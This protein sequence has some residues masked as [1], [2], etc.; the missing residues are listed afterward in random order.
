MKP[1]RQRWVLRLAVVLLVALA[2]LA[3]AIQQ[4]PPKL[5][6]I[7][8]RSGRTIA[9][10]D[11]TIAG[12][13]SSFPEV[14]DGTDVNAPYESESDRFTIE[15]RFP[16]GSRIRGQFGSGTLGLAGERP[17]L[18]IVPGGQILVRPAGKNAP[19]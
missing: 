15:G 16:D 19:S 11:V 1:G 7:E 6:T 2:F 12:K 13:T 4:R 17:H 10:L 9:V 18:T 5:L 8:N 3:F 14:R